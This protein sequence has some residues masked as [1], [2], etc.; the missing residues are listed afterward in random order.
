MAYSAKGALLY[1]LYEKKHRRRKELLERARELAPHCTE[2]TIL[3]AFVDMRYPQNK[4]VNRIPVITHFRQDYV[5]Y[6]KLHR[7]FDYL[8]SRWASQSF[9]DRMMKEDKEMGLPDYEFVIV[10]HDE[11]VTR[12]FESEQEMNAAIRSDFEKRAEGARW[13]VFKYDGRFRRMPDGSV[14]YA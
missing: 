13:D 7:K 3:N 10:D 12:A 4:H 2:S 14:K 9:D 11:E 8:S 5:G 6:Y 1:A